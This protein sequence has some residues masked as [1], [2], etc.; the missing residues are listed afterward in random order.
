VTPV[1]LSAQWQGMLGERGIR[2]Q[3]RNGVAQELVA[4]R[5]G[6]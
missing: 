4:E 6:P 5:I 2:V 1:V 3:R